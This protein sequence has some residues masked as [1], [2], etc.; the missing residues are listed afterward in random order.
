MEKKERKNE[1]KKKQ[2]RRMFQLQSSET[3]VTSSI[4][5]IINEGNKESLTEFMWATLASISRR[6]R[7]SGYS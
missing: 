5:S 3:F 7:D 1:R 2:R 4:D 6:S